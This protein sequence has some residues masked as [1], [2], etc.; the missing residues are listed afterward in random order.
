MQERNARNGHSAGAPRRQTSA[1]LERQRP[2][3]PLTSFEKQ[4]KR[5]S[6]RMVNRGERT[7]HDDSF[8][9]EENQPSGSVRKMAA[10]TG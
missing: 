7:V 6:I 9:D 4:A 1:E 3:R 8:E 5:H 2:G 10:G